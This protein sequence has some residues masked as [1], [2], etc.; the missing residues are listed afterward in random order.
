MLVFNVRLAGSDEKASLP[1]G[2][3]D[4]MHRGLV[5]SLT[6]GSHRYDIDVSTHT[7]N[8]FPVT[9]IVSENGH[10]DILEHL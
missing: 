7:R 6:I 10:V 2:R 3:Y 8:P 5:V 9:V 4:G 1:P